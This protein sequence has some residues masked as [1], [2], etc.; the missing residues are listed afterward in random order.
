MQI[1]HDNLRVCYRNA[2]G[3]ETIYFYGVDGRK[4]A[5][6]TCKIIAYSGNPEIRLTQQSENVYFLGKLVAAESWRRSVEHGPARIGAIGRLGISGAV[7]IRC[8]I[9]GD[10][11]RPGEVRHLY[12]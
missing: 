1:W 3:A 2:G 4:L 6:Y 12:A 10:G 8:G 5:T 9:Y 11:H 7:S